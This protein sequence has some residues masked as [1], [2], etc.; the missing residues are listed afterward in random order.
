M[1]V[2]GITLPHQRLQHAAKHLSPTAQEYS[3]AEQAIQ[4][5]EQFVQTQANQGVLPP[6]QSPAL[7]IV[8]S[9]YRQTA[10][11]PLSRISVDL[12]F[13]P[14][15]IKYEPQN[16]TC[17]LAMSQSPLAASVT[18][19][20]LLSPSKL[21]QNIHAV[22]VQQ[23][24]AAISGSGQSVVVELPNL[25]VRLEITP[26][27]LVDE[28]FLIPEEHTELSWR[29]TSPLKEKAILDQID[30]KHHQYVRPI[31]KFMKYWNDSKNNRSWRE[32]HM[33]AMV[34]VHFYSMEQAVSSLSGALV[35]FCKAMPRYLYKTP[36]LTGLAGPI[37]AYLPDNIDQWYLFMN[38]VAE[39]RDNVEA[40]DGK[41]IDYLFPKN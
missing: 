33:E 4:L 9:L 38:R 37:S 7:T 15:Q 19:A 16:S 31:I 1:S 35:E 14:N 34:T 30:S 13:D 25:P 17:S 26:T 32:N 11:S 39:L 5:L 10:I 2:F 20:Q 40:G 12:L 8:G 24:P 29:R 27:F 22:F 6:L 18:P 21:L 36:D 28:V 23:Y 3:M 41:F